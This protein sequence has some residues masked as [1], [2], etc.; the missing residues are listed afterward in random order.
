MSSSNT[1]VYSYSVSNCAVTTNDVVD[2]TM[3]KDGSV[4]SVVV[5][6]G[7]HTW[8]GVVIDEVISS[9]ESFGTEL[10]AAGTSVDLNVNMVL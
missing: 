1:D 2:V 10:Y 7:G 3:G 6:L 9:L 4:D 5:I 8:A